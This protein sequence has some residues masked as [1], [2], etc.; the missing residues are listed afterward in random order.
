[1]CSFLFC[2]YNRRKVKTAGGLHER[3]TF[4]CFDVQGDANNDCMSLV[5]EQQYF[6]NLYDELLCTTT[7]D[8][9]LKHSIVQILCIIK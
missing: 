9:H 8:D 6:S 4:F 3:C 1:M 5:T 7:R 2:L